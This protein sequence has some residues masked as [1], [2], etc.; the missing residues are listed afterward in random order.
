M[1]SSPNVYLSSSSLISAVGFGLDETVD[2]L[3]HYRSGVH[4]QQNDAVSD[5]AIPVGLID[6]ARLKEQVEA[7]S[8][9]SETG[10]MDIHA[11]SLLEQLC[12]LTIRDVL[13]QSCTDLSA[14]DCGL[15]ISTT[16]GN[17][18]SLRGEK[19]LHEDSPAF[20]WQTSGRL[21]AYFNMSRKPLLVSNACI[22]G[23]SA[24]IVARRLILAGNYSH[25][26]VVG[27]DILSHF[28]T[29]G[30]LSFKS[31]SRNRCVPYD[32]RHDGLN[33]G[34][35][36]GALL[37]SRERKSD[38]DIVLAGGAVTNDAHHISAP[39]RT[40]DGLALAISEAMAEAEA[41]AGDISFVNA[42]GTSTVYN[43]EM[44][45]KA[46][47]LAGLQ[48]V[49]VNSTKPY[50][51][52]TLGAS[53][54]VD[55]ILCMEE[56]R[57]NVLFGTLGFESRGVE[58]PIKVYADNRTFSMK[59]CVKTASGFGGCNA[60]VVLCRQ[61]YV[62]QLSQKAATDTGTSLFTTLR[63]VEITD[64][65]VLVDGI[66]IFKTDSPVFSDFVRAAYLQTGEKNI[67]FSKKDDLAKLGYL[68]SLYLLE[69]C[70]Y[71]GTKTGIVLA[72]ASASLH[73]DL[74]HEQV[75]EA[76]GDKGARPSVFVYTLPNVT[77]GEI[78]IRHG[79]KGENTFFIYKD[80]NEQV[81]TE[82]EHYAY[83]VVSEKKLSVCIVGWCELL[84]DTS[85]HAVFKLICKTDNHGRV[86]RKTEEGNY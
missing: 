10:G 65:K 40:G 20:L 54:V 77:A 72:N 81:M 67:K 41:T 37:V 66:E 33:L 43:D 44:E 86:S 35:A 84:S 23:V 30:F 49:P 12:I 63:R 15:I 26:I 71:D 78:C 64:G 22:S 31:V 56:L 14:P 76:E 8:S 36:C 32:S 70:R 51:G 5:T 46:V 28:I 27:A 18:D 1:K 73:A 57:R 60:A 24:L 48:D 47:F 2:A 82:L 75:I 38:R 3:L 6:R 83:L 68:T 58:A 62:S 25:V 4:I 61:D 69:G 39:S 80:Y 17:V 7:L 13:Q 16:K 11:C 59:S 79:I 50:F 53:G 42:H 45:A 21:A 52:H 85:Y 74:L 19:I 9:S 34:E 55:T 29:S